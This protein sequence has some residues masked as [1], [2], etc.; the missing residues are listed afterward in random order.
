MSFELQ[1]VSK[2]VIEV[3]PCMVFENGKLP[4]EYTFLLVSWLRCVTFLW[5]PLASAS[6]Q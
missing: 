3:V 1:R 5:M 6:T 2:L 4:L